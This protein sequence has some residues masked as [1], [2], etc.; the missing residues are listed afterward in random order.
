MSVIPMPIIWIDWD[1]HLRSRT[2]AQRLA[3]ELLEIRVV[4]SRTRR[5]LISAIRTARVIRNTRPAVV[6]ATNPSLVLALLSLALRR[7]YGFVLVADAHYL[8]VRALGGHRLLQ[9]LLDFYN[10]KAD[11]VIVTNDA[12][13]RYLGSR[14]SLTGVC[15]DPLPHLAP[16]SGVAVPPKAVFLVCS[17]DVDEP[18]QVAFAAFSRLRDRGYVLFVSGDYNRVG[19]DPAEY[20]WV[21]L[22]GFVC[23]EEYYSYLQSCS[24]IVNLTTAEDCLVCGAYEAIAAG[25]ALVVSRTRAL[26]DYFGTVA[27]LTDNT[28]DAIVQSIE[29][30][31]AQREVLARKVTDWSVTNEAYMSEQISKLKAQLCAL[32]ERRARS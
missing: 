8:G 13:A 16:S 10:A 29:L 23:E 25:K 3:V 32:A 1:R 7:W 14:G 31:H 19:I 28:P 11:L 15:P 6:I 30:A 2:L 5:Y 4:G 18:Y 24:V 27:V 12:H 21:N 26:R 9:R 17:F 20:P 22:L